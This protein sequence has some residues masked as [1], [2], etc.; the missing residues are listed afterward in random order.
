MVT[1]DYTWDYTF[2]Y[3]GLISVL[4]SG[5]SGHNCTAKKQ[6]G[7]THGFGDSNLR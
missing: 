7:K 4:I 6:T 3:Y 5:I 2:H 1:T